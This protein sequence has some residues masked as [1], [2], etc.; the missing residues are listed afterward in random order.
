[1]GNAFE[2]SSQAL[3]P[4]REVDRSPRVAHHM[5]AADASG[6]DLAKHHLSLDSNQGRATGQVMLLI[7]VAAL[8]TFFG[9]RT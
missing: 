6:N 9:S 2:R 1:M 8:S 7:A 3:S 4:V 5:D